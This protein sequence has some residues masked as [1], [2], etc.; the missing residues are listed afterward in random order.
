MYGECQK[1]ILNT[2]HCVSLLFYMQLWECELLDLETAV[3]MPTSQQETWTSPSCHLSRA[4]GW[5]RC[6]SGMLFL[7]VSSL[8]QSQ[9]QGVESAATSLPPLGTWV[10]ETTRHHMNFYFL[11]FLLGSVAQASLFGKHCCFYGFVYW[12]DVL[13]KRPCYDN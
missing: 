12:Y 4:R 5:V 3:E 9:H 13:K 6:D 1:C 10:P 2:L 7:L 8:T 11:I